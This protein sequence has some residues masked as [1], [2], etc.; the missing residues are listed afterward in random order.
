MLCDF[1]LARNLAIQ[2]G[3]GGGSILLNFEAHKLCVSY[4][5]IYHVLHLGVSLDVHPVEVGVVQQTLLHGKQH[6]GSAG[7]YGRIGDDGQRVR[8][9]RT[10]WG[11][12]RALSVLSCELSCREL[13]PD[14]AAS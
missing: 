10:Y 9:L 2:A 7:R 13:N 8:Y 14:P 3:L 1:R 11:Y 5:I 6:Q 12:V 4:G